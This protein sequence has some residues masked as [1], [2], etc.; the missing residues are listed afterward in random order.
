MIKNILIDLDNTLIDFNEC[1]RHAI[2]DGFGKFGVEY[3]DD[4]LPVFLRENNKLW[5]SH[6]RG[7]IDR[8]YIRANR[9]NIIFA[10]LGIVYD[11]P[12][13]ELFFEDY[14]AK[15]AYPVEGAYELLD[16]LKEKYDLYIVSNG[17]RAVQQSRLQ[18]GD[19]N[20]YLK[21]VF[22]SEDAGAPKPSK[23][24]FDYC[25]GKLGGVS[26]DECILIGD[27]LT[28]DIL[29]GNGYGIKTVW[30]DRTG[31]TPDGDKIPTYT[32]KKLE[33]IKNIL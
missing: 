10:K 31:E 28:A 2:I 7:E 4:A 27:S 25:F 23:E 24:F 17:F 6:E 12:T 14:I 15:S 20:K 9:W 26:V 1:A 16:Y 18:K 11:G 3:T 19:F 13:M 21:G 29:G 33:E 8:A 5:A 30:F 32:V 22:V